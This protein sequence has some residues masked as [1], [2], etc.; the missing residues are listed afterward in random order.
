MPVSFLLGSGRELRSAR[1]E[2]GSMEYVLAIVETT[3]TLEIHF[4]EAELRMLRDSATSFLAD[5]EPP[6]SVSTP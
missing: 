5:Y 1:A 3:G 4:T 6:E 2:S